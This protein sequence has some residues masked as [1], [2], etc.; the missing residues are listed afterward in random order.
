VV[1]VVL[2]RVPARVPGRG[3][4]PIDELEELPALLGGQLLD[5][6][7]P[8][9]HPRVLGL[10]RRRAEGFDAEEL[11]GGDTEDAGEIGKDAGRG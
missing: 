7:K 2:A 11:V 3:P 4:C 8:P 9:P 1:G 10:L 5:L 6:L